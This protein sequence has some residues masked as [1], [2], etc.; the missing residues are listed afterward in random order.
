M[1]GQGKHDPS[2]VPNAYPMTDTVAFPSQVRVRLNGVA[3]GTYLLPDDP[4]DHRGILSWHSQPHDK[5][6]RE[7]GSYGYRVASVSVR[8]AKNRVHSSLRSRRKERIGAN[9][10]I[11]S[12]YRWLAASLCSSRA[13]TGTAAPG[14]PWRGV[15]GC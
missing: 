15:A 12:R 7:A 14:L 6:L 9:R 8:R 3:A 11:V 5:K 4:A 13:T 10:A 1:L 2:K